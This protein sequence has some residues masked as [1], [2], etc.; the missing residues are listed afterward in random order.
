MPTIHP[1]Q[2]WRKTT[3]EE[4]E[5]VA[6]DLGK[7]L[8]TPCTVLLKGPMGVGK[9]TLVCKVAE[10]LGNQ[11]ASSPTFAIHQTYV[12]GS[13]KIEHFD[14]YRLSGEDDV[15]TSGLWD[16]LA[17]SAPHW[18]FIE[19]PERISVDWLRGPL[20]ELTLSAENVTLRRLA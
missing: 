16:I 17:S 4:L 11:E 13:R 7:I 12:T 18:V 8:P 3:L 14:L 20:F 15:E 6:R 10:L 1:P 2:A 19:W 5:Q 9:T